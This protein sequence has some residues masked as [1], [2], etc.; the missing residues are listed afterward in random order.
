MPHI[1][2]ALHHFIRVQNGYRKAVQEA[3]PSFNGI[4]RAGETLTPIIDL[5][6][7]PDWALPRGAV[8][9]KRAPTTGAVA[10][11][12]SSFELVNPAGSGV[13]AVVRRI[14]TINQNTEVQLELGAAICANPIVA[15]GSAVDSRW[16]TVPGQTSKCSLTHGDVAAG[17]S[18]RQWLCMNG[19]DYPGLWW[20]VTP[21]F[22]LF[23]I[24]LVANA[25]ITGCFEWSERLASEDELAQLGL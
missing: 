17:A 25:S 23:V 22:K 20:V 7:E 2:N 21:G 5:W 12:F 8:Y 3:D 9:F 15:R 11:R 16:S 19:V 24:S 10:G 18:A 13:I 14:L 1:H 4:E 6:A